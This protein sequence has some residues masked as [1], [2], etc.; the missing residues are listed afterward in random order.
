MYQR[1]Q[2]TFSMDNINVFV[3]FQIMAHKDMVRKLHIKDLAFL[4]EN[5]ITSK[6]K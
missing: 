1:E 3:Y 6:N 2:N 4:Y 5:H